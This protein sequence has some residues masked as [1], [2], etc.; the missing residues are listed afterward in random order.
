MTNQNRQERELITLLMAS[1][2]GEADSPEL[3]R[4][5]Q[6][7]RDD[8]AV[9]QILIDIMS[10]EAHFAW[11]GA[12]DHVEG[13]RDRLSEMIRAIDEPLS[14]PGHAMT[15]TGEGRFSSGSLGILQSLTGG[16]G[17][18]F[19][20]LAA[21]AVLFLATGAAGYWAALLS[22]PGDEQ[23]RRS[24]LLEPDEAATQ[25]NARVVRTTACRW[26]SE[27]ESPAGMNGMLRIGEALTLLEGIAEL[28]LDWPSG[29]TQ[30]RIEGPAGV[31]LTGNR[32][33][34]LTHGTISCSVAS[35]APGLG[36][37]VDT[38]NG[39]V[40][41]SGAGSFGVVAAGRQAS[42]HVFQGSALVTPRCP[43]RSRMDEVTLHA[44]ESVEL[45]I[46]ESGDLLTTNGKARPSLFA[47]QTPM[48]SDELSVDRAYADA[49]MASKPILYW[50]FEGEAGVP[51]RNEAGPRYAGHLNGSVQFRKNG[52]NQF[53]ELGLGPIDENELAWVMTGEPFEHEIDD[54]YS[55]EFWLKPNHFQLGSVFALVDYPPIPYVDG[56]LQSPHGL[57]I[58]LGGPRV[59][60][61]PN[62][63]SGKIR[64]L[65]RSPAS[66]STD[67]GTSC[68]SDESYRLRKWQHVV[69][70]KDPRTM[71]LYVDGRLAATAEDD[72]KLPPGLKL[73][74]GQIDQWRG[75]RPYVGQ[76]DEVAIYP[77]ALE[78]SVID[79]HYKQGRSAPRATSPHSIDSI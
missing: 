33:V 75:D 60:L 22:H 11:S 25:Y 56:G 15:L 38:A 42:V 34:N 66:G 14:A 64:F 74:L 2:A 13:L 6:L 23:V 43:V 29:S 39:R 72:T 65:H 7:V 68:F 9:A 16:G 20:R 18:F 5:E 26:S 58:E 21:A 40:Q 61:V 1:V 54:S 70:V 77:T 27:F 50:R 78:P 31:I 62:Q 79:A 19:V 63:R 10:H 47:S 24:T 28:R 44:G 4:I 36:F 12:G 46:A 67:V 57:L 55:I 53:L 32:T 48:T 52:E 59:N 35:M 73:L 41:V 37:S 45:R 51:V 76:I 49:V 3:R 69:A 71:K 17:G 8:R 30:M